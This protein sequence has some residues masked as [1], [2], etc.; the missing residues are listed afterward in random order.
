MKKCK[1]R[2]SAEPARLHEKGSCYAAQAVHNSMR[3]GE[4]GGSQPGLK[5]M[6]QDY[7]RHVAALPESAKRAIVLLTDSGA[8]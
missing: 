4:N 7:S 2:E 6:E 3:Q 1:N 8:G 5:P